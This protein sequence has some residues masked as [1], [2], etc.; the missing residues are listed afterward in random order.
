MRIVVEN[1]MKTIATFMAAAI[2][3][4]VAAWYFN[5]FGIGFYGGLIV[6]AGVVQ[7]IITSCRRCGSWRTWSFAE[8]DGEDEASNDG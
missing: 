5:N 1:V 3:L 7:R 2:L 8:G 4:W 6:V